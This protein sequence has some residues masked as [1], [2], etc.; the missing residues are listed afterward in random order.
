MVQRQRTATPTGRYL[1][2]PSYTLQAATKDDTYGLDI[3]LAN[4]PSLCTL[5]HGAVCLLGSA[6]GEMYGTVLVDDENGAMLDVTDENGTYVAGWHVPLAGHRKVA[7][8]LARLLL[9]HAAQAPLTPQWLQAHGWV[10]SMGL[11]LGY[12][13]VRKMW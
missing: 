8:A 4:Y 12:C 11:P 7:Q 1:Q 5:P 10:P 6:S 3:A 13:V 2:M 9:Q